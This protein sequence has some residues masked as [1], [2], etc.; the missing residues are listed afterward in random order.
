M[1]QSKGPNEGI[2]ITPSWQRKAWDILSANGDSLVQA[3][4][5]GKHELE[6]EIGIRNIFEGYRQYLPEAP[7][8]LMTD[9]PTPQEV[10]KQD[11]YRMCSSWLPFGLLHSHRL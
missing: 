11:R 2:S 3:F 1:Q 4:V 8:D 7:R 10:F 6:D 9:C 5:L